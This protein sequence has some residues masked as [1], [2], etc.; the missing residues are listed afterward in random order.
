[1]SFVSE[2][3][4]NKKIAAQEKKKHDKV[5]LSDETPKKL[6]QIAKS[7]IDAAF[8]PLEK[9]IGELEQKRNSISS[10]IAAL[11]ISQKNVPDD[12]KKSLITVWDFIEKRCRRKPDESEAKHKKRVKNITELVDSFIE[13]HFFSGDKT[14]RIVSWLKAKSLFEL[15]FF[16]LGGGRFTDAGKAAKAS[17][18]EQWSD[19]LQ[20]SIGKKIFACIVATDEIKELVSKLIVLAA[21]HDVDTDRQESYFARLYNQLAKDLLFGPLKD[22]QKSATTESTKANKKRKS[23]DSDYEDEDEAE[24]TDDEASDV[25]DDDGGSSSDESGEESS[26]QTSDQ[27]EEDEKPKQSNKKQKK[28]EEHTATVAAAAAV[29][30]TNGHEQKQVSELE[31][32]VV[33]TK[34]VAEPE[35]VPKSEAETTTTTTTAEPVQDEKPVSNEM[36]LDEQP[37][38]GDEVKT[39]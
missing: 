6:L 24:L 31:H 38:V 37:A 7:R 34:E 10:E 21:Q 16:E 15:D 4:L 18:E 8:A 17:Q 13:E 35:P 32:S 14:G 20:K 2:K 36:K 3:E 33:V 30:E 11:E 22:K 19:I 12:Q 27:D 5:R 1:M 23:A 26:Q 28:D 9:L 29:V 39:E 25:S